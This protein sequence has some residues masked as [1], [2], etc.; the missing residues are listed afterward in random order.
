MPHE[1]SSSYSSG[2]LGLIDI[3]GFG[4][5]SKNSENFKAILKAFT[6]QYHLK[7]TLESALPD[8]KYFIMSDTVVV[9][10][11]PPQNM[12]KDY[13]YFETLVSQI[14]LLRHSFLREL[15]LFSRAGVTYGQFY[16]DPN[17]G[18]LFGPAVTRAAVLAEKACTLIESEGLSESFRDRPAAILID[19][20]F[21]GSGDQRLRD[22]FLE[23]GVTEHIKWRT[24]YYIPKENEFFLLNPH[25]VS[26]EN[27]VH[28]D[29]ERYRA[30][31]KEDLLFHDWYQWFSDL[32]SQS[33]KNA[34]PECKTKYRIERQTLE[35]FVKEHNGR[36]NEP[37][38]F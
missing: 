2:Y 12:E 22:L 13:V 32:L 10:V 3:L 21:T 33:E 29:P 28:S 30:H 20:C 14:A 25:K 19:K 37:P 26:M 4:N 1:Q 9:M 16:F 7:R 35:L 11:S 38:R 8:V 15:G 31:G 27:F 36:K 18:I 17:K 23:S 6:S 24:S 5:F 34:R